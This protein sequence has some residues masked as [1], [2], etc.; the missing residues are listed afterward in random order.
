MRWRLHRLLADL[1]D[2]LV[3]AFMAAALRPDLALSTA[4]LGC[5]L[6][7]KGRIPEA[8]WYL[9]QAIASNPFDK[10]AARALYEALRQS[11]RQDE[12]QSLAE[13]RRKL[14]AAASA[15]VP[16]EAWFAENTAEL[17]RG[18]PKGLVRRRQRSKPARTFRSP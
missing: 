1:H 16:V 17:P 12:A 11:G 6:A 5:A 9:R 13:Q 8:A 14:S 3:H 15:V 10:D 2:D 18:K 4:S 7:R